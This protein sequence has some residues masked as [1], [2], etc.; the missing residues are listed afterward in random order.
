MLKNKISRPLNTGV[1][2]RTLSLKTFKRPAREIAE[3]ERWKGVEIRSS[4]KESR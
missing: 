2:G 4:G 3:G 1:D